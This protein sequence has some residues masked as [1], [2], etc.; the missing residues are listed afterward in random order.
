MR[1]VGPRARRMPAGR[2]LPPG[3]A[4]AAAHIRAVWPC[5]LS[6]RV[7]IGAARQQGSNGSFVSGARRRHQRR[8]T[9]RQRRVHPGSSDEQGFNHVRAAV[10]RSQPQRRDAQVVGG[11]YGGAGGDQELRGIARVPIDRPVQRGGAVALREIDVRAAPAATPALPPSPAAWPRRPRAVPAPPLARQAGPV[12]SG[13][14]QR[15]PR[16]PHFS[17]RA[18]RL[19]LPR[20]GTADNAGPPTLVDI[21]AAMGD[22]QRLY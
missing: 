10:V 14:R 20:P 21:A 18:C 19:M 13:Q 11:I 1:P 2:G 3:G 7:R 6:P 17:I 15:R 8:L 9:G 4:A 12:R 22:H 16:L 5:A